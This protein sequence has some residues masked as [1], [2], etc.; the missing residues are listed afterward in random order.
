MHIAFLTSEY[1]NQRIGGTVGGIG[2]FVKNLATSLSNKGHRVSVFVYSQKEE[3]LI[4]GEISIYS[5]KMNK[6]KIGTWW[7]KRKHIESYINKIISNQ[8]IDVIEAPEWTGITAF[9]KFKA[10]LVIRLHG[11]DTFFCHLENRKQKWKNYF[12]EKK[13]LKS[14][15][16]IVGVSNFVADKTIEL[17]HLKNKIKTIYNAIDVNDFK[18]NHTNV[19]EKTILY[20]G[21][22]IRK[23][24]V[25]E[26]AKIFNKII[27]KDASIKLI[28]LGRDVKDSIKK[29]STLI[30]FKELLSEKSKKQVEYID[31]VPYNIVKEYIMKTDIVVLPSFAEAFPMTWLEAMSMEKKIVTSN[32]G[33]SSELMIDEVTGYVCNPKKSNE[34]AEKV[35]NLVKYP[36]VAFNMA[37][38]ARKRIQENFNQEKA[39]QENYTF[40]KKIIGN[41]I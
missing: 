30:L 35:I 39:Y 34:F 13:A 40:Y 29:K 23:K 18:P 14:A 6:T 24:G 11:S 8:K 28:M 7:F 27:E 21:T 19:K 33:W 5:I 9:M 32:I 16:A 36:D 12:F 20:F 1:P 3:Y 10:P 31:S 22:I 37:Q 15:N 2:S 17:F 26:L 25:L 38:N 41:E 4:D